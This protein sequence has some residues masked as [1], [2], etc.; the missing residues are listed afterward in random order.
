MQEA[1]MATM[2]ILLGLMM[3]GL[4][5]QAM[6]QV[7][8][9]QTL[10]RLETLEARILA[11]LLMMETKDQAT[12]ARMDQTIQDLTE[13]PGMTPITLEDL[14][15]LAQ[16]EAEGTMDTETMTMAMTPAIPDEATEDRMD[17]RIQQIRTERQENLGKPQAGTSK[18]YPK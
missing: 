11:R 3:V 18:V 8:L 13:I 4:L 17:L 1:T 10:R 5:V 9:M 12:T 16:M 2:V 6:N 15:T 7:R 14:E